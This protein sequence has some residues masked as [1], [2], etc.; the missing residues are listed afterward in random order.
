MATSNSSITYSSGAV[1]EVDLRLLHFNDV[2]HIDAGSREPVGGAARFITLTN[3]YRDAPEFQGQPALLTFFS[4]DV[5]NPS[6]E[7]TVTKGRHMV[8][9]L[10]K[11]GTD[12]ACLGNHDLD[13][14][15][16]QLNYLANQCNFPWLVAN[17]EDPA[18]GEGVSIGGLPKTVMLKSSNGLNVGV[19]G[20]VEREWL[21]TINS[22]PPNLKYTNSSD[23]A[24]ALVPT[25]RNAGADIVIAVSHQREPNDIK[26]AREIPAGFIDII[27]G[28]HDHHYAHEII[29][30]CHIIR[31]GCDFK[32]LSYIEARKKSRDGSEPGWNFDIVRRDITREIPE[33]KP[34]VEIVDKLASGLKAKLSKPIGFTAVPLDARFSTVRVAESNMANF[35]CD[36]IRFYYSAD[37]SLMAAGTMRG[38]QI[39][40][41]GVLKLADIVNCFPFEDPIVVIRI[42]GASIKKALENGISKLPAFEGRFPHVSNI[43]YEYDSS[44]PAGNRIISCKING[45][46]LVSDKKY[47]MATRHYMTSGRDGYEALTIGQDG[48]D[49]IVDEENG[50]LITLI[51]RQYFLSLK[52]M[53]KW[54]NGSVFKELFGGLRSSQAKRGELMQKD[55]ADA[56]EADD[57]SDSE[58]DDEDDEMERSNIH[59]TDSSLDE[60]AA[61]LAKSFGEKWARKAGLRNPKSE[62]S[63]VDWTRSIA[64]KVEGRIKDIKQ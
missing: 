25:L 4:G 29:N 1:G 15:V 23:A 35:V 7:S 33:D 61:F 45:E 6:L 50:V 26:L 20:L 44:L 57:D 56:V 49:Y 32:Q 40:P 34:T 37:C 64:P 31:S 21:D 58:S 62:D 38:D 3:H 59:T 8:P 16:D 27:L 11:I 63:V 48:I 9:I 10:N 55:G 36:L 30:G 18:L 54:H 52:V 47:T 51:L 41:P 46:D 5:F 24:M 12:V 22:L 42:P 14:G 53:G 19:I 28:G 17:V 2:Y 39:Y 13:F 43:F 60:K